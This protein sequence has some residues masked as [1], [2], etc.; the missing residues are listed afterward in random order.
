[1]NAMRLVC[2]LLAG[3]TMLGAQVV[4]GSVSNSVTRIGVSDVQVRLQRMDPNRGI[5]R[6]TE[7]EQVS[8]AQ[9]E[10]YEALTDVSGKFRIEGVK[11]GKYS[12]TFFREGFSALRSGVMAV[13]VKAGD[14]RSEERRVGKES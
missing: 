4:E 11:D 8:E 9:Q 6:P 5:I 13:E 2:L 1:M 10:L 7:A 3:A 14:P 12:V